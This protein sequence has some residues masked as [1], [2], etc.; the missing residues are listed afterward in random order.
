MS[1][2]NQTTKKLNS[3]HR[4]LMRELVAGAT[5]KE[6]A[7]RLGFT[8]VRV[9]QLVNSALFKSEMARMQEKID[10]LFVEGEAEKP[11]LEAVRERLTGETGNSLN[12]IVSLRDNA[13]SE[14]VRQKSALEILDRAGVKAP[15]QIE[16]SV[17]IEV[18]ISVANMLETALKEIQEN[19]D[20]LC[21]S[22]HVIED[23]EVGEDE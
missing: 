17:S 15:T 16:A 10:K 9:S 8:T 14:S 3:R 5:L 22:E 21:A 23:S 18:D 2:W 12:T 13:E 6:A 11:S 7:D 4:A 1:S 20:S 19:K